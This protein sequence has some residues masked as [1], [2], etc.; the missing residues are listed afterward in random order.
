MLSFLIKIIIFPFFSWIL[1]IIYLI[2]RN[3]FI[4]L[5][6][7]QKIPL[8]VFLLNFNINLFVNFEL[9]IL[10]N[11]VISIFF[12]IINSNLFFSLLII[13][14]FSNSLIILILILNLNL[15]YLYIY[16]F[17]IDYLFIFLEK[18]K[19]F[20][21]LVNKNYKLNIFVIFFSILRFPLTPNF[22]C[23]ILI[24]LNV[25]ENLNKN[26]LVIF[27]L[28]I[29]FNLL[30]IIKFFI[31]L[32]FFKFKLNRKIKFYLFNYFLINLIILLI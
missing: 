17:V 1:K 5:I 19:N 4:I 20:N 16:L 24:L 31:I 14:I 28:L 7:I 30:L 6:T 25:L 29:I 15:I 22:F 11:I 27:L 21:F 18:L 3:F 32:S 2:N 23:K 8:I 26:L 13:S 12:F 9:I 10:I